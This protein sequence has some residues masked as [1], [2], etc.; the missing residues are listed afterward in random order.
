MRVLDLAVTP[1][2]TKLV[3]VTVVDRDM[4]PSGIINDAMQA[5]VGATVLL[6]TH[7]FVSSASLSASGAGETIG[8]GNGGAASR[9]RSRTSLHVGN[10]AGEEVL[11]PMRRRA[12]IYDLA[13]KEE[14]L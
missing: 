1:D 12:V 6:P 4:S 9:S 5:T 14:I 10:G 7:G 13:T 3:A 11:L 2:G 8:G